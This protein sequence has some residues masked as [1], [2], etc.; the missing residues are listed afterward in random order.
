M[1]EIAMTVSALDAA[2]TLCELRDWRLSNLEIQK[3]LY[4]A[5]MFY[6]GRSEEPLIREN[7][8]AWDYG[9]VV[10]EVYRQASGFGREP[11]TNRFWWNHS[12]EPGRPGYDILR[13]AAES[14]LGISPGRLVAI[15]HRPGG[16]W[17]THYK[18][19]VRGI[20]IP[21]EDIKA[22][23]NSLNVTP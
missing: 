1:E 16:A 11:V 13:E 10:P 5:H 3:I 12:V 9:P 7:F 8:E 19:N 21:N 20:V 4:L 14:T 15:T 23:Y 17:A 2:R 6:F 18:P 22:E